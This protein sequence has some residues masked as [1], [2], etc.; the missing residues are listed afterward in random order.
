MLYFPHDMEDKQKQL[1]RIAEQM[2]DMASELE[3]LAGPT[4]K[5][6]RGATVLHTP[7][8]EEKFSGPSGGI[9]LLLK[10]GFFAQPRRLFD[11]M[12]RLKQDGFNYRLQVV[13]TALIRLTRARVLVRLPA[14]GPGK[15]KW[16]YA[17]RK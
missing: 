3:H 9:K 13:S 17:E 5:S 1:A 10:E 7:I 12:A 15:E 8:R 2:R 16:A 14:D 4:G 11:V 6:R